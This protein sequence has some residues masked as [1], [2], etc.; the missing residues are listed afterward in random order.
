MIIE[1][2][3]Y[4]ICIYGLQHVMNMIKEQ[5]MHSNISQPVTELFFIIEISDNFILFISGILSYSNSEVS[6]YL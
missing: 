4:K 2:M 6:I 3:N 1:I 5:A